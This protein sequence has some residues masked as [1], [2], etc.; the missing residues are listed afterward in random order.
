LRCLNDSFRP[1]SETC[2]VLLVFDRASQRPVGCWVSVV[3]PG[4]I[5]V[6]LSINQ[7]IWHPG[8]IEWPLR[9]FPDVVQVPELLLRSRPA[10]LEQAAFWMSAEIQPLNSKEHK[11]VLEAIPYATELIRRC[12]IFGPSYYYNAKSVMRRIRMRRVTRLG[13]IGCPSAKP[14][15]QAH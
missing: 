13:Q 1:S 7:S 3:E 11:K 10:N 15:A 6:A 8:A 4:E 9:G 5:E 12:V 14:S 2:N